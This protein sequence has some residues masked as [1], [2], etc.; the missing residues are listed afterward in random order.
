MS[1]DKK[2]NGTKDVFS[3]DEAPPTFLRFLDKFK[4]QF[5]TESENEAS[6]KIEKIFQG[7][8]TL[9]EYIAEFRLLKTEAG[10]AM[11]DT[12]LRRHASSRLHV[13]SSYNFRV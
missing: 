6:W 12:A 9:N 4:Q 8:R 1:L 5:I 3:I 7:S 13:F 2:F 10:T 11:T